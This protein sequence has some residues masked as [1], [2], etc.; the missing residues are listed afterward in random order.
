MYG[1]PAMTC[2]KNQMFLYGSDAITYLTV[3]LCFEWLQSQ[4]Y[5]SSYCP[6]PSLLQQTPPP[7]H[8]C[9]SKKPS[10]IWKRTLVWLNYHTFVR[11]Q[12]KNLVGE[13]SHVRQPHV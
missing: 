10:P 13:P 7:P 8:L 3:I 12:M 2:F 9:S 6:T 4:D 11:K 5:E 1:K